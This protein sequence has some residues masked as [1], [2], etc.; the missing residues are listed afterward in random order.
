MLLPLIASFDQSRAEGE[1]TAENEERYGEV[2][3]LLDEL[4]LRQNAGYGKLLYKSQQ[5]YDE[6]G[7]MIPG[8]FDKLRKLQKGRG[9]QT[10]KDIETSFA[11]L[12]AKTQEDV[13]SKGMAGTTV[14]GS[15]RR[16]VAKE[17]TAAM[18]RLDEQLLK[19][20]MGIE[21]AAS[22]ASIRH[23]YGGIDLL[24]AMGER[25]LTADERMTGHIAN[26]VG[27]RQDIYPSQSA[28]IDL[29]SN[30]G[31]GQGDP[32]EYPEP[33]YLS[34][35]GG[36]AAGGL[37][38][39]LAVK[40]M[41]AVCVSGEATV[42]RPSGYCRLRNVKVGDLVRNGEFE[43]SKVVAKD[44]GASWPERSGDFIK[45]VVES[46][47]SITLTDDHPING[48]KAGEWRVNDVMSVGERVIEA[49]RV[50]AVP[51]GDLR[52]ADGTT[53]L[54]NGFVVKS[55]I[56]NPVNVLK[57]RVAELTSKG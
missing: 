47:R 37:V 9:K 56:E 26:W 4:Q 41:A 23:E 2:R 24:N 55:I 1:A 43:F 7:E 50:E 8:E 21:S 49:S 14:G 28:F 39:G 30:Y 54:A 3:G 20:K 25:S 31:T 46:G 44:F 57:G 35:I 38:T 32:P 52:L 33:D 12:S 16:G 51:S 5:D 15:M 48:K 53:Y 11:N 10:R 42:E 6:I 34:T 36:P 27:G 29:M 17:R 19:E 18:G 22:T 45:I 13:R 40:A